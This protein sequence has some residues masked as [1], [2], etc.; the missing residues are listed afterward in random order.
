MHPDYVP[1]RFPFRK[2]PTSQGIDRYNRQQARCAKQ[3][4][5]EPVESSTEPDG[6]EVEERC[7]SSSTQEAS[8]CTLLTLKDIGSLE[9]ENVQLK[10]ALA[11]TQQQLAE[12]NKLLEQFKATNQNIIA[13]FHA[14]SA[15]HAA[16]HSDTRVKFYTGI[17][18]LTM[19]QT[20]L[21]FI[22]NFWQ[23]DITSLSPQEQ[24]VLVL[25]K[26]RLGLLNDD[27]ACRFKVSAKTVSAVFHAWLDVLSRNFAKLIV[28]PSRK[29]VRRN[30]PTVFRDPIFKDVIG[31]LDCTEIFI[32]KPSYMLARSQTYSRYKHHNTVK[33]LIT[34]SPSGAI[35]FVSKAW[36]GRVSDKELTL[37]SGLLNNVKEGD[38]YLVDR[39]FRCEEMFAAKGAKLLIPAF[40]KGKKQLS[41]AEVTLSRKLSRARIHVERAIRRLK[42]FRIF[43]TVLP[44]T[45]VKKPEDGDLSTIDKALIVCAA[46]TNLQ[47]PLLKNFATTA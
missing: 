5:A 13:G 41:G 12:A 28:W 8:V 24:F 9:S 1:S 47:P 39:G 15:A 43:Q 21:S 40:T 11:A 36:G 26:L 22:L 33:L 19:F 30:L 10:S 23:P 2:P 7:Q 14:D 25:M 37:K 4:V 6:S 17:A 3:A 38:V 46:L 45:F 29:A 31:V 44:I 34:V 42:V 16:L 20:L 27:L 35:T 32:Q 18:S